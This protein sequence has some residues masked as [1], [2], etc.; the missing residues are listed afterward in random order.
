MYIAA[1]SYIF[2]RMGVGLVE[3]I[4]TTA[5]RGVRFFDISSN[6]LSD[7]ILLSPSDRKD[8]VKCLADSGVTSSSMLLIKTGGIASTDA[9]QRAANMDYMKRCAEFQRETGGRQVLICVGGYREIGVPPER[10]WVHMLDSIAAYADWAATIDMLVG[11]EMEPHVYYL[12]YNME[13]LQKAI[14]EVDRPNVYPNI[15]VGHMRL[16]REGPEYLDR[17]K[18]LMYHGHLSDHTWYA[19]TNSVTGTNGVEY[20]RYLQR[21]RDLGMAGD[22]RRV[23][24]EPVFSLE[25]GQDDSD[26]DTAANWLDRSLEYVK[27]NIPE[28]SL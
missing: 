27:N 11:L 8:V 21:C 25:I 5:S 2:D 18:G 17:F 12:L 24:V 19:H 14:M 1:Q 4:R 16:S 23:G 10:N 13:R 20:R 3:A 26:I 15:D 7:P 9:S 6:P 28:L 22:S